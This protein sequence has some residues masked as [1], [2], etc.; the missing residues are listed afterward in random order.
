[1]TCRWGFFDGT[2]SCPAP[3]APLKP[4][5]EETAAV[6]KWVYNDQVAQYLLSQQLPDSTVVRM[7]PYSTAALCW[8]QVTNEFTAKSVFA[9]NNLETAF[10]DMRC[11]RGGDVRVFLRGVRFKREELTAARV[12]ITNK[13][14]QWMVLRGIPE[15]L[16]RFA[17]TVLS[18]ARLVHH[19]TTVDTETLI[20]HIC[21]EADRIKSSQPKTHPN[22]NQSGARTQA[23]RD[24]AL[25]ATGSEGS[26]RRRKGKCHNC[27]KPGHWAQECRSPK[28]EEKLGNEAPKSE[29]KPVGSANAVVTH[30]ED[31]DECWVADFASGAPDLEG[32]ALIDESDWLCEGSE[33]EVVAAVI[34]PV[35]DDRGE[36]V[37]LYDS[38]T[39]RHISPYKSNFATYTVLDLPVYLNTANQQRF[40]AVRMGTLAIHAP[41]SRNQST[42]TLND[43][44]HA[45]AVG[46][47]LVSL[48]ALDK[49]GYRASIGGN[50][51]LFVPGGEHVAHIPQTACG[52][53]RI[54]HTGESVHA[55]ET[56]SVMELHRRMGHIVP[57]SACALIEKNLVTGIKLDPD[58]R[59][60]QCDACIFACATRK[61]VPKLHIGPQ[62]QRFGEEVH[63]DVWGPLPVTSKCGCRYF[64]TFTDDATRYI[65]T[66]LLCTKA[67]ALG[68]YKTF[69][70]WALTQQHC[71]AIKV[72]RSDRS[73]E[74]LSDAFDQHL[75]SAGTARHLT[76]HDT[77][78]VTITPYLSW[79]TTYCYRHCKGILHFPLLLYHPSPR[80]MPDRITSAS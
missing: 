80:P 34:T 62:A 35:S 13:D 1:M 65:V 75:K 36:R 22:S 53:Y 37:K 72:L 41:N 17:S 28:K 51:E 46:Y 52:L 11:L 33:G 10:Y 50:L 21:E 70:A 3:K 18:S 68:A 14:Y 6:E 73:G 55:V 76:V 16:A 5:D 25:A 66:Y 59:E 57:A 69:E 23:T 29:T 63:T 49:N 79:D 45:L 54:K 71:A 39:T 27:G 56:I 2:N 42:L 74:Y 8:E 15:E 38:G 40:P 60:T 47:T 19:V 32:V 20:E 48:G 61:P 44:L 9:Q 12:Y 4:T 43:I 64:I 58:S 30:D 24:K 31:V 7:G 26:K 78:H 67:E 77:P